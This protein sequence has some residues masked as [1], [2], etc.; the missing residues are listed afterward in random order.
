MENQQSQPALQQPPPN[1]LWSINWGHHAVLKIIFLIWLIT[2]SGAVAIGSQFRI[3][4]PTTIDAIFSPKILYPS[5]SYIAL[6][7]FFLVY[8]VYL[9][10]SSYGYKSLDKTDKLFLLIGLLIMIAGFFVF[11]H[12][13]I[14]LGIIFAHV[15]F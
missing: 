7:V 2:Y 14:I 10:F 4:S 9:I 13:I 8:L 12:E 5:I 15:G 1:K 11:Y 6:S 3:S